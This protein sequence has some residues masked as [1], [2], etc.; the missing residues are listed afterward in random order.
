M[1]KLKY[2]PKQRLKQEVRSNVSNKCGG[3]RGCSV[4]IILPHDS[5]PTGVSMGLLSR[6]D[7]I[8]AVLPVANATLDTM[9]KKAG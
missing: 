4:T 5:F 1:I 9:E 7:D 3:R 8:Q 6:W 2:K